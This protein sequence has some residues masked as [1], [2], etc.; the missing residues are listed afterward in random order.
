MQAYYEYLEESNNVLY[1]I[2]NYKDNLDVDLADENWL[3][4]YLEEMADTFP[5]DVL[6]DKRLLLKYVRE[7]YLAKG[8]E[9]SYRFL[10]TILYNSSIDFIYPREEMIK[11][12]HGEYYGDK[13]I[14]ITRNNFDR[15][16]I[17]PESYFYLE[18]L[19]TGSKAVINSFITKYDD[20]GTYLKLNVSQ[21]EGNFNSFST[22]NKKSTYDV[23]NVVI[24]DNLLYRCITGHN[25]LGNNSTRPDKAPA[26]WELGEG[27]AVNLTIDDITQKEYIKKIVTGVDII[28][29]GYGYSI[30]DKLVIT[31]ERG[32]NAQATIKN[33]SEGGLDTIT[34][35]NGGVLYK[36][37]EIL[38]DVPKKGSNGYGFSAKVHSVDEYG[39]ITGVE[40]INKGKNYT[41][42]TTATINSLYGLNAV[43][44]LSSTEIGN[45]LEIVVTDSGINYKDPTIT[46]TNTTGTNAELKAVLGY[47]YEEPRRY[48]S[49]D[50]FP[51]SKSKLQDSYYYQQF[52]YVV[53]SNISTHVWLDRMKKIVHP[54]GSMLFGMY[55]LESNSTLESAIEFKFPKDGVNQGLWLI[56]S[57]ASQLEHDVSI[58]SPQEFRYIK[59][60]F[61]PD[62]LLTYEYNDFDEMK[63][64]DN[65]DYRLENFMDVIFEE[66]TSEVACTKEHLNII[67]AELT[68]T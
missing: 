8:T 36:V 25:G 5:Q 65:F 56:L 66:F 47:V 7:F 1:F 17:E 54:T 39:A 15:F 46:V 14:Y 21:N 16:K 48:R 33:V 58:E 34:I 10:F 59:R 28:N 41:K 2:Q 29:P 38:H 51:S 23:D 31:D 57:I 44:E 53:K 19:S 55:E 6:V 49:H 4:D 50:N 37:G 24:Y 68:I 42:S 67:D 26:L 11:S 62:C 64:N 60:E 30:N 20:Y 27:E 63:F 52:S 22:W 18:G 3:K 35:V 32:S 9:A 13:F 12:S 45:I 61:I 40:I 43:I